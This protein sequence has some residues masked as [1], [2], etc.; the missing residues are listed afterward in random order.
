M[1]K[2]NL[3]ISTR[4]GSRAGTLNVELLPGE[5]KRFG[6]SA[7]LLFDHPDLAAEHLE[8]KSDGEFFYVRDLDTGVTRRLPQGGFFLES[9]FPIDEGA[10]ELEIAS[11]RI[12][13]KWNSQRIGS[14]P[15][16]EL[17]SEHTRIE[18]TEISN[19]DL[20][21]PH[22]QSG[23]GN[24][25][26]KSDGTKV[27]PTVTGQHSHDPFVKSAVKPVVKDP[28][29]T[30]VG[31]SASKDEPIGV[32]RP[33]SAPPSEAGSSQVRKAT[34]SSQKEIQPKDFRAEDAA[35]ESIE[36]LH[37][38]VQTGRFAVAALGTLVLSMFAFPS[39]LFQSYFRWGG[40]LSSVN[41]EG[42]FWDFF[43][44]WVGFIS[45]NWGWV[46]LSV[47]ALVFIMF[48]ALAPHWFYRSRV[49]NQAPGRV[50][51]ALALF[52]SLTWPGVLALGV[53]SNTRVIGDAYE[54]F[55]RAE[56][57]RKERNGEGVSDY[58]ASLQ[59]KSFR[60]MGSSFYFLFLNSFKEMKIREQCHDAMSAENW[61]RRRDCLFQYAL[62]SAEA[63]VESQP[64]ILKDVAANLV[65]LKV[66]EGLYVSVLARRYSASETD[67]FLRILNY[68][69][70]QQE[71]NIIRSEFQRYAQKP[72]DLATQLSSMRKGLERRVLEAYTDL[73]LP[74]DFHFRLSD[75]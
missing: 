38:T 12:L 37:A 47:S 33:E 1:K 45:R 71:T 50:I 15:K 26:L 13:L 24:T 7:A 74:S 59:S 35:P 16:F 9:K 4:V 41:F 51:G 29:A 75:I 67:F 44:L 18:A 65:V 11:L 25:K 8:F 72:I 36:D 54:L 5:L 10:L 58:Y 43:I 55:H 49:L 28:G 70:L 64:V 23:L 63:Y 32:Y 62:A 61:N 56:D 21:S 39:L 60:F 14:E 68:L 19:S 73:K 22:E 48:Q 31:S 6:R 66:L 53:G 42:L 46:I 40:S 27:L 69:E 30:N 20:A 52:L 2:V 34:A 17:G 57:L 3:S